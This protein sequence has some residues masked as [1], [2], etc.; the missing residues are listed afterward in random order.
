MTR[1]GGNKSVKR[2]KEDRGSFFF[3]LVLSLEMTAMGMSSKATAAYIQ[4][5]S[6]DASSEHSKICNPPTQHTH[7]MQQGDGQLLFCSGPRARLATF[8]LLYVLDTVEGGNHC[9]LDG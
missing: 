7:Q 8:A 6:S 3:H 1:N 5:Q 4:Y 2:E 9:Y